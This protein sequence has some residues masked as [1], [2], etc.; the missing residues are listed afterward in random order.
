MQAMLQVLVALA[1]CMEGRGA[2]PVVPIDPMYLESP[3]QVLPAAVVGEP[4]EAALFVAGG[5]A[6]YSWFLVQGEVLPVGLAVALDGR[7]SGIPAEAGSF[8]FTLLATDAG[9]RSKRSL[10]SL[11]VVLEPQVLA[12]GETFEGRFR[13]NGFGPGGPDLTAHDS[14]EWLALELPDDLVTRVELV[15]DSRA[16]SSLYVERP[17]E[18]PGSSN[19]SDHY[20]PVYLNPGY[21]EMTVA[22]DAGTNPSLT[23][24]LTDGLVPMLLVGQSAG[25]WSVEVVCT[26]GPVFV[27]VDQYPVE[28]GQPLAWDWQVYGDNS[29]VRIWTED[30]LPDWMIW[31]E[32]TGTL[33]GT[34]LEPGA[35]EFTVIAETADGRR[36]EERTMV[37]VYDVTDVACGDTVP[38]SVD[39]SYF[40]GDFYAFYDPKGFDV[41]RVALEGTGISALSLVGTGSD[42]YYLGLADPAPEWMNF[43]GG[44][45]RLYVNERVVSLDIDP[46][47][48]PSL[49]HYLEPAELYFSAGT[50]GLDTSLEVSVVCDTGPRP[51]L[52]A[53]PV[54][55][56]LAAVTHPLRAIGGLPP[57]TWSA[58]GLPSGITLAEDGVLQGQTGAIGTYSVELGVTDRTGASFTDTYTLYVGNDE[59]C[60]GYRPILC[61]D[62]IDGTFT[63]TY[64]NDGNGPGSTEVFCIVDTSDENLG[65]EL[66]SDDGELR[67]DVADPGA[68]AG[69]MFDLGRG[70]YVAWVQRES[71]EGLP[72]DPYAWPDIDDYANLPILVA[73]RAYEPGD[74]TVHLVC[75]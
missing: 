7:I 12:C 53:L 68:S 36:R 57:Y 59:A 4:Y 46:G 22:L 23:G 35:W 15:F 13:G 52:A 10:V 24:Y 63:Q 44:A 50:I 70:T 56:P 21:T 75:E 41:F 61:G 9:G 11:E 18:T 5:E 30:P 16:I 2:K 40:D 58:E 32:T 37:G 55:Q 51:D 49:R 6:P 45:E 17:T 25:D 29:D 33:T 47:T 60:A 28:L 71:S 34:A 66:F 64:Y 72:I 62:S 43:Y 14:L 74:W 19:I 73:I 3:D 39:E 48:Y 27:T 20:V 31:D 26:D 38:L 69:E 42:G 1:G 67:V 54:I 8:V 65:F